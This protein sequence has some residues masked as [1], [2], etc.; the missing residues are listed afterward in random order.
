[1]NGAQLRM[2]RA[3]LKWSADQ[4][5]ARSGVNRSTI[6]R[7]EA[8][9]S[10]THPL[11]L[12][13]MRAALEEAGLEFLDPVEGVSGSGVRFKWGVEDALKAAEGASEASPGTA[14]VKA[15]DAELEAFWASQIERFRAL[16]PEGR[17]VI[18]TQIYGDAS[19]ADEMVLG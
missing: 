12:Q 14:G 19:F 5:A 3:A 6:V 15:L 9:K 2:A 7:T 8:A 1:M 18:A 13:N 17:A 4:L 11:L 10:A 16:S